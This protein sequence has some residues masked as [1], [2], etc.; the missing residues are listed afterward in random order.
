M[1]QNTL[2]QLHPSDDKEKLAFRH[3]GGTMK[4][5]MG[6]SD[7]LQPS[8]V[9]SRA[10]R[11][12]VCSI[13]KRDS[14]VHRPCRRCPIHGDMDRVR[15]A[16]SIDSGTLSL[17]PSLPRT[18]VTVVR[19]GWGAGTSFSRF[20]LGSVVELPSGPS[21]YGLK[22]L[23]ICARDCTPKLP[24]FNSRRY[25]YRRRGRSRMGSCVLA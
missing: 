16:V 14:P 15:V 5:T 4:A 25:E 21:R 3:L 20:A 8:F 24:N 13:D 22:R 23:R 2:P 18:R 12:C 11:S 17:Q 10:R 1:R 19:P 9:D 6:R 7:L